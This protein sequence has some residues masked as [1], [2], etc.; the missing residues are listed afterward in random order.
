MAAVP[1]PLLHHR[2]RPV[3]ADQ[4]EC[5]FSQTEA[6]R[7]L[8][9]LFAL[10]KYQHLRGEVMPHLLL[11]S[12]PARFPFWAEQIEHVT[13]LGNT[14]LP[15]GCIGDYTRLESGAYAPIWLPFGELVSD[16]GRDLKGGQASLLS[17]LDQPAQPYLVEQFSQYFT[18][19]NLLISRTTRS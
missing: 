16:G 11:L 3:R 7:W 12:T 4:P 2:S 10:R 13:L 6:K 17:L 9:H 5:L 14:S 18:F 1:A 8:S 15:M 19:Q